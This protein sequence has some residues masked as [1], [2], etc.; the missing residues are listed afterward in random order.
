MSLSGHKHPEK[1][2]LIQAHTERIIVI[3]FMKRTASY[4]NHTMKIQGLADKYL[5]HQ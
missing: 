3:F 2:N 4:E 5:K 1:Y